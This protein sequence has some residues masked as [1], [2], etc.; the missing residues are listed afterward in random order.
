[1]EKFQIT[2][3]ALSGLAVGE[4]QILEAHNAAVSVNKTAVITVFG[5][6][7][8]D[9]CKFKSSLGMKES[10]NTTFFRFT[11]P[12]TNPPREL[13]TPY[14]RSLPSYSQGGG[15]PPAAGMMAAR[16]SRR[17]TTRETAS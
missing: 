17:S 3:V 10:A 15:P 7:F 4:L 12:V 8:I 2:V 1:M 9:Y 6:D 13:N 5:S 14:S 16:S 11:Q